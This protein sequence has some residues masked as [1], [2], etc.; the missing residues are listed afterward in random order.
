MSLIPFILDTGKKIPKNISKKFVPNSV[1]TRPGEENS[2]KNSKKI[3]K[4]KK[5]LS[6]IIYCQD[7]DDISREREKEI[8]V[9][10]SVHTRTG[11]ENSEKN[12]KKF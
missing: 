5:P 2:K 11:Q 4:I 10:N 7:G 1:H 6:G 8:L 3:Q 9:P 12:C